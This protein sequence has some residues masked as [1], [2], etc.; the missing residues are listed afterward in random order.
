[1]TA[2]LA[3]LEQPCLVVNAD[4]PMATTEALRRLSVAGAALVAAA[5]GTTN[6]LSLP[7]PAR[8]AP[9]YGPGSAAAYAAAGFVSV[10]IPELELDVDTSEDLRRLSLPVGRKTT[11][12]LN[13]HRLELPTAS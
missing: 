11:L 9:R 12:V 1:M 3:G 13:H 6:A 8:F 2:G 10:S 7:V 4:L 5:D